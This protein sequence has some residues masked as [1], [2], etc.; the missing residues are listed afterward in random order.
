MNDSHNY[1]RY[2]SFKLLLY[3]NTTL[4]FSISVFRQALSQFRSGSLP[5]NAN[6]YKFDNDLS[7]KK[8]PFCLNETENEQHVIF[9]CPLYLNL[10]HK[11]I[12]PRRKEM[13]DITTNSSFWYDMPLLKGLSCFLV[14]ALR[15]RS[16]CRR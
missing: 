5:I 11:Y 14:Y 13:E 16:K 2:C 7:K 15:E 6:L 3:P 9:H 8:C 12:R 10:R 1:T 4:F